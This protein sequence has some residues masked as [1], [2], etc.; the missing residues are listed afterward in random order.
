MSPGPAPTD[1]TGPVIA[2][3]IGGTKLAAAVV[4]RTGEVLVEDRRRTAGRDA[5]ELFA[6]VVELIGSR[7]DAQRRDA[8]GA[9]CGLRRPDV[10]GGRDGVAAQHPA[11][12]GVPAPVPTRPGVRAAD[13]G[14][15]RCEGLRAGR[16]LARSGGRRGQ[17]P[18]HGGL[19]RGRRRSRAGRSAPRRRRRQRRPHRPRDRRSVWVGTACAGPEVVSRPRC[20]A[21]SLAAAS[22]RP[23]AEAPIARRGSGRVGWSAAPWRRSPTCWISGSPWWPVRSPWASVTCSSTPRRPSSI[24]APASS[25]RSGPGSCP[26]GCGEHGPLLGAAAIGFNAGS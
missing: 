11:V 5:E 10:G 25:T 21:P 7:R 9:R 14:R 23:A 24:A 13:R 17:L 19:D 26:V 4:S 20:P 6:A 12:A 2:L 18:G 22:G 15:Q 1:P 8:G 16:G 3:D